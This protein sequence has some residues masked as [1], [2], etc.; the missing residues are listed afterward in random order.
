M[1]VNLYSRF[2]IHDLRLLPLSLYYFEL[3]GRGVRLWQRPGET[4]R[5]VLLKALGFAMFAGE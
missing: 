2:T 5:H 4:Y 1:K 3:A